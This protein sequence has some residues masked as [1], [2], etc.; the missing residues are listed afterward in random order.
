LRDDG[1]SGCRCGQPAADCDWLSAT[2]DEPALELLPS[3]LWLIGLGHLG[4]AYLWA[5]GLLPYAHPEE[6]HLVLQDVDIITPSTEST[7]ILTD[8]T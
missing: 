3:R 8:A 5:L 1:R 4:Q 6:T 7:S 2:A